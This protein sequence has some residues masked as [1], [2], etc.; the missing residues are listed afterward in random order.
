MYENV[1]C[2]T[3]VLNFSFVTGSSE[4]RNCFS[5]TRKGNPGRKLIKNGFVYLNDR[6]RKSRSDLVRKKIL[7]VEC[8]IK[9]NL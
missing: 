9:G 3:E 2:L 4:C 8:E 6:S 1:D 5:V 7:M